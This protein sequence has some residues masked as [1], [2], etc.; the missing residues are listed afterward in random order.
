MSL[1]RRRDLAARLR[2]L[3]L[4]GCDRLARPARRRRPSTA[5]DI[6][7]ADFARAASTLPDVDGKPRTLDDFKGKVT[8]RLLR[9]HAVPGRLPDDDGRAGRRSSKSLGADGD[10]LQ[11]VFVTVDPERDTPEVLKAYVANF[12]PGFI[13]LRGTPEQTA[14]A[15]KEFKVFYAKVPGKTPRQLHDGPHRRLV[16]ASTA[17]AEVRLFVPLR[18]RRDEARRRPAA[19]GQGVVGASLTDLRWT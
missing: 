4:A 19:A 7:G 9:L 18:R 14:A 15:A 6:T 1:A 10:K 13:A 12:G 16:R 5:T 2:W 11:G 3:A 17:T 8:V